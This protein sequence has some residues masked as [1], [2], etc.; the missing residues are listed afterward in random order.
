[1]EQGKYRVKISVLMAMKEPCRADSF[2]AFFQG[3]LPEKRV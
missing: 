2:D 1:M 3:L